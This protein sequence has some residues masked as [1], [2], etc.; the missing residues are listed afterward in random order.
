MFGFILS[1]YSSKNSVA[2]VQVLLPVMA[3]NQDEA[4][5]FAKNIDKTFLMTGFIKEQDLREQSA[6]L[7]NLQKRRHGPKLMGFVVGGYIGDVPLEESSGMIALLASDESSAIERS[8]EI[9]EN[10]HPTGCIS[11]ENINN[12]I[13][14]IE[15]SKLNN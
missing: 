8:M 13:N 6:L 11:E 15:N 14:L 12:Y 1:G 10:F 7:H 3:V 2:P 9:Q 5:F 4:L